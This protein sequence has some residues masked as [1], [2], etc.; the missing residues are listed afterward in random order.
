M[1]FATVGWEPDLHRPRL[2]SVGTE[3]GH[4]VG[5]SRAPRRRE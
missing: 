5:P 4:R 1:P 2:V 3:G